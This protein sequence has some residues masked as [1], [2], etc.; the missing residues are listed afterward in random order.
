MRERE[1]WDVLFYLMRLQSCRVDYR[2]SAQ[3]RWHLTAD[4]I[5][6]T[7]SLPQICCWIWSGQS[8]SENLYGQRLNI[9]DNTLHC[10]SGRGHEEK[11]K[12]VA[13]ASWRRVN[14]LSLVRISSMNRSGFQ[15][16]NL[17]WKLAHQ[18]SNEIQIT[19]EVLSGALPWS[20]YISKS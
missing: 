8:W 15:S 11:K 10:H 17:R 19:L 16:Q 13:L 20:M 4:L 1:R 12:R 14:Y 3:P 5:V 7:S 6:A 9:K 2:Q 18:Q